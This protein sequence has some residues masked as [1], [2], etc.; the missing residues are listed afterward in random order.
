MDC[1]YD[2]TLHKRK[3][4]CLND[5]DGFTACCGKDITDGLFSQTLAPR[6]HLS[7]LC[8][9]NCWLYFYL[10]QKSQFFVTCSHIKK[11]GAHGC[12]TNLIFT[13]LGVLII[14]CYSVQCECMCDS[15]RDLCSRVGM[16]AENSRLAVDSL[17]KRRAVSMECRFRLAAFENLYPE[18]RCSPSKLLVGV[19]ILRQGC[20]EIVCAKWHT[21]LWPATRQ[22]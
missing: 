10:D 14:A 15:N 11:F 20:V 2:H 6:F 21:I 19:F 13:N 16:K 3:K 9:L 5:F 1:L 4:G 17:L 18:Q 8:R 12:D 22:F 7:S